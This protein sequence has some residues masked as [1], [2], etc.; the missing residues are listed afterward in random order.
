MF[1]KLATN[2]TWVCPTLSLS[3]AYARA[4]QAS[5]R[6]DPR[7]A[8]MPVDIVN[9]WKTTGFSVASKEASAHL[10]R[11]FERAKDMTRSM[12]RAGVSL[13][14]GTDF[15]ILSC[16]L[17][18]GCTTKW[19]CWSKQVSSE[20]GIAGRNDCPHPVLWIRFR[21]GIHCTWAA[22]RLGITG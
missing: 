17:V 9:R 22:G 12:H 13:L 16:C 5:F 4:S 3:R 19:S 8:Y 14:A 18:L 21:F 11:A 15:R 20:R 2:G 1:A 7:L 6:E 10:E